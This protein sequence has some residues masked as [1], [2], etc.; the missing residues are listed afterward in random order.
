ML[1]KGEELYFKHIHAPQG[2]RHSGVPENHYADRS[3][4]P[5]TGKWSSAYRGP[6]GGGRLTDVEAAADPTLLLLV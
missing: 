1:G 6:G 3:M 2:A 5:N 4:E